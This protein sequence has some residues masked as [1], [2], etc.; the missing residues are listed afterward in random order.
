MTKKKTDAVDEA[1]ELA[2]RRTA[3]AQRRLEEVPPIVAE[4]VANAVEVEVR[5]E[6]L[7]TLAEEARERSSS[8]ARPATAEEPDDRRQEPL[9]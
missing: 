6:E 8:L 2:T 7:A 1:V 5:A 9:R 4:A 3:D